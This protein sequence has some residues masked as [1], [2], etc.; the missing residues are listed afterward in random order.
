MTASG[1]Q[2]A[3]AI[4]IDVG[5]SGARVAAIADD[6]SLIASFAARYD[7]AADRASPDV[8]WNAVASCLDQLAAAISLA[9][10]KALAVDGT[11]GTM[12][13]LDAGGNPA[14]RPLMYDQ[15]CPDT[16]IIAAVDAAAPADSPARGANSALARAIHLS[17]QPGVAGVVHQAD[18]I[19]AQITGKPPVS[20]ANNALKTGYDPIAE[21]WP[22][23]IEAAGMG[24]AKLPRVVLPGH[25]IG[26]LG[27]AAAD[28]FG[29]PANTLIT[30][31]TTDGC[32]SFLA[33][34]AGKPG[35][36]VTAL[37]STL[38][39]K[40]LCDRPVNAP[41]YGIYS[42]RL[43]DMWLAGGASN[44][45]GAVLAAHFSAERLAA[46]T[47]DLDPET[48]TGLDYYPLTKPGERFPINDPA[49]Q[50]R[51]TPRP[52][53]EVRFLQGLL[54]GI[55]SVEALGY[56]RLAEIGAP[57]L[58]SVRTVGGGANNP[59]FTAI[60]QRALG[61]PFLSAL[62]TEAA[63]GT[64]RLALGATQR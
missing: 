8:W 32:A 59:A 28:R 33:T 4:G 22:G 35:D 62:S 37:G 7:E 12:L 57:A 18:W 27:K 60:R 50:P 31:G 1:R 25:P 23:W 14:A 40:L 58:A 6:G 39:L 55:T 10:V 46:L 19:A 5:T 2:P 30:G 54:E 16:A 53:N 36:A 9:S 45:G 26:E 17:R 34:G 24:I 42:H 47:P 41:Q 61:V 15:P 44:T 51:I 49:L 63:V 52:E 48:P 13:G 11:S 21:T 3:I 56:R 29:L 38:V 64:A 20:D 43:G